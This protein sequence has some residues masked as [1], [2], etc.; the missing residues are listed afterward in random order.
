MYLV[1]NLERHDIANNQIIYRYLDSPSTSNYLNEFI[2]AV[3]WERS[4]N[5]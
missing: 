2:R 3:I 5:L 4:N 1:T